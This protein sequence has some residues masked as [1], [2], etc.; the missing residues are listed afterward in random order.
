MT[1]DI[2]RIFNRAP[3]ELSAIKDG[4]RYVIPV[5]YSHITSDVL[6]YAQAQNPVPGTEDPHTFQFE[7]LISYVHPDKRKQ[8]DS[9]DPIPA[10]TLALM[11]K[12]RIDRSKLD[13]HRQ[14]GTELTASFPRGRVGME[15]PT[16]GV[17]DPGNQAFGG[18]N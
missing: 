18:G 17:V 9:L 13:L 16:S 2:I 11:P 12:E 3:W 6:W 8:K 1:G 15:N 5:G 4:R 7:S 14:N 10:E